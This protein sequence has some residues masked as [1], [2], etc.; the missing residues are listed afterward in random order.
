MTTDQDASNIPA[1]LTK[2]MRTT[3]MGKAVKKPTPSRRTRKTAPATSTVPDLPVSPKVHDLGAVSLIIEG[4]GF[5]MGDDPKYA[6]D[7]PRPQ[8]VE[9]GKIVK[10]RGRRRKLTPE[11][12]AAGK[13][14]IRQHPELKG[15]TA[16]HRLQRELGVDVTYTTLRERIIVPAR[17]GE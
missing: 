7:N 4:H 2:P 3:I 8:M 13:E 15:L 12:I 10:P 16:G 17:R 11:Q 1:G 5:V 9:I 14:F 6:A